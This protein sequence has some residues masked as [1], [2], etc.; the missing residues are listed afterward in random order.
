MYLAHGFLRQVWQQRHVDRV[1]GHQLGEKGTALQAAQALGVGIV[2][3][4]EVA[5]DGIPE[6]RFTLLVAV[7]DDLGHHRVGETLRVCSHEQQATTRIELGPATVHQLW[8]HIEAGQQAVAGQVVAQRQHVDLV[9]DLQLARG[10]HEGLVT[11]AVERLGVAGRSDDGR[12]PCQLA[13]FAVLK[14]EEVAFLAVEADLGGE[15]SLGGGDLVAQ[16]SSVVR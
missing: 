9:V 4:E 3:V 12:A 2:E 7:A 6:R 5:A 15:G 16:A 14:D 8:Q 11:K 1:V 13:G 10:V